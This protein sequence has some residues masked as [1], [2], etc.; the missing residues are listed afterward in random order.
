M[1][2]FGIDNNKYVGPSWDNNNPNA[3]TVA[4]YN[5]NKRDPSAFVGWYTAAPV[6]LAIK[7]GF[8]PRFEPGIDDFQTALNWMFEDW[9]LDKPLN[10]CMHDLVQKMEDLNFGWAFIDSTISLVTRKSISVKE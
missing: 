9:M 2:A 7:T 1:D 6:P 4:W 5:N 10:Q 3:Y 8:Q